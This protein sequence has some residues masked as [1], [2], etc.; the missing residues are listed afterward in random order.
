MSPT[1]RKLFR[2]PQPPLDYNK[3]DNGYKTKVKTISETLFLAVSRAT[4]FLKGQKEKH[5]LTS[6]LDYLLT[7]TMAENIHDFTH[8]S[9]SGMPEWLQLQDKKDFTRT[10]VENFQRMRKQFPKKFTLVEPGKNACQTCGQ[11]THSTKTCWRAP[12]TWEALCSTD[13]RDRT[14]LKAIR[15]FKAKP[16][17]LPKDVK[18]QWLLMS[19]WP[20]V[21]KQ[22]K[23][24]DAYT[25]ACFKK[26][27]PKQ[28]ITDYLSKFH[29]PFSRT[30]WGVGTALAIGVHKEA[31]IRMFFGIPRHNAL[32]AP[33]YEVTQKTSPHEQE[34]LH[35]MHLKKVKEGKLAEVP[36]NFPFAIQPNFLISE[37]DK[38]REIVDAFTENILHPPQSLK[39]VKIEDLLNFPPQSMAMSLDAKSAFDQVKVTPATAR[40]QGQ[41]STDTQ[42]KKHYYVALGLPMG[43]SYCPKRCQGQLKDMLHPLDNLLSTLKV[44][45]DDLLPIV[46]GHDKSAEELTLIFDSVLVV[47][48]KLGLK[49]SE[50]CF[51]EITATPTY[52]GYILNL[53]ENCFY[54]HYKHLHKASAL[55][56]DALNPEKRTTFRNYLQIKGVLCFALKQKGV[57]LCHFMDEF[58]RVQH[59]AHNRDILEILEMEIPP[60]QHL[61]DL[62]LQLTTLLA[63]P[64]NYTFRTTSFHPEAKTKI[65]I[66]TDASPGKSGGFCLINGTTPD[67]LTYFPELEMSESFEKSGDPYHYQRRQDHDW[68]STDIER[69][70][71]HI[72]LTEHLDPYLQKMQLPSPISMVLL[73]DSQPLTYQ[74]RDTSNKNP[75]TNQEIKECQHIMKKWDHNPQIFWHSRNTRLGRQADAR[76]RDNHLSLPDHLLRLIASHWNLPSLHPFLDMYT[77][78]K[79]T[80]F[81]NS[82]SEITNT[83]PG[84]TPV[85]FPHPN[86]SQKQVKNILEFLSLREIHGIIV[87]P[88]TQVTRNLLPP[89][90]YPTLDLG[91][92][93]TIP[94][95]RLPQHL[96]Q[97]KYPLLAIHL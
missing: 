14:F 30:F 63:T 93:K 78:K 39:M 18:L 82:L 54:P 7:D 19:F 64:E 65:V 68:S 40:W 57:H 62:T 9:A 76:T 92:M 23:R 59:H 29:L 56:F 94:W 21:L 83:P 35:A 5:A 70:A 2:F 55:I 75:L 15:T 20:H 87:T 96:Q 48:H 38:D 16:L 22:E 44:Y 34:K 66:A 36:A 86:V 4:N 25:R 11:T 8:N 47:L 67:P 6:R 71:L 60:N 79:I 51:P 28:T 90:Q 24:F 74:I 89:C 41:T 80:P 88:G 84:S 50:K 72:F 52:L 26:A 49:I 45:I 73:T 95:E 17:A 31:A 85:I 46:N 13:L 91:P 77:L 12:L 1:E 33:P 69:K 37:K 61:I 42:G 10:K 3:Y 32:T 81:D 43:V 58:I 27:H 97:K 53:S